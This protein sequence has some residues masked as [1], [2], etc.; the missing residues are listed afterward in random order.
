M[1]I[2]ASFNSFSIRMWLAIKSLFDG[3]ET[4]QN[5]FQF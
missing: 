1:T 2:E 5:S 3:V 4:N